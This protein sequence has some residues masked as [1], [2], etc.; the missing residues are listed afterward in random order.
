MDE[1]VLSER[2]G[3]FLSNY[4]AI[5]AEGQ[6]AEQLRRQFVND[7]PI[8]RIPDLTLEEYTIGSGDSNTFCYRIELELEVLGRIGG[9]SASKQ[10]GVY[11]DKNANKYKPTKTRFGENLDKAFPQVKVT[12]LNL[13]NNAEN[14]NYLAIA[15]ANL[16]DL[17]RGKLLSVYFPQ[18]YLNVFSKEHIDHYNGVFGTDGADYEQLKL[19]QRK[20]RLV[21]FKNGHNIMRTWTLWEY[22][23][24]L[25]SAIGRPGEKNDT[26]SLTKEIGTTLPAIDD[27]KITEFEGVVTTVPDRD[28][29]K[30]K[31]SK[32][33]KPRKPNYE[34][35]QRENIILGARGE[36]IA[37]KFEAAR[38]KKEGEA[39]LINKLKQVSVDDDTLGYDILSWES[40]KVKRYIEVKSTKREPGVANFIITANELYQANLLSNYY[41][42]VVFKA[43]TS[44]PVVWMLKK[45]FVNEQKVRMTPINYQVEI[46][47][48]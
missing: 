16:P 22:M 42:Y 6:V 9:Q 43:N 36:K 20:Q 47:S 41:I 40:K 32:K 23:R 29:T 21:D 15:K 45:P 37:M 26:G 25:Y 48:K 10:Y 39:S 3:I 7:F 34:E 27:L 12:I 2:I 4:T 5:Q 17:Y 11:F 44:N 31:G 35:R 14:Q 8:D 28:K 38:L 18:Q 24:F 19:E 30:T 46:F 1:L 33:S 13:L